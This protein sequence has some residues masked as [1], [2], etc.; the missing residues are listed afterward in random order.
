LNG[1]I[2]AIPSIATA[3]PL[4]ALTSSGESAY[5]AAH[6]GIGLS[7]AQFINPFGVQQAIQQYKERFQASAVLAAPVTNVSLFAFCSE[8]E[9][10]VAQAKA[11]MDYRLLSFEKG[12]LDQAFCYAD[13]KDQS[14]S[15]TEE[16]RLVYHSSRYIAGTPAYI[17]EAFTKLAENFNMDEIMVA[18]FTDTKEDR[19]N[20]YEILP[21]IFNLS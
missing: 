17:K 4:W 6:F 18:T 12:N 10:K 14:Y 2:I 8:S 5:L 11:L 7:Y 13:I 15:P 20:S 16:Q 1:K 3:P 21:G 19:F 9:E